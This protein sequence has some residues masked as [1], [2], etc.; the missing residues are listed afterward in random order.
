MVY[1]RGLFKAA[2]H[3]KVSESGYNLIKYVCVLV[4]IVALL[5]Q[6]EYY[7]T[8]TVFIR[9]ICTAIERAAYILIRE[10][11]QNLFRFVI[12]LGKLS[13]YTGCPAPQRQTAYFRFL[14]QN[15]RIK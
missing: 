14:D 8:R 3:K 7:I 6:F 9:R 2:F 10:K 12:R 1:P 5:V 15:E 13:I 4:Y 11:L